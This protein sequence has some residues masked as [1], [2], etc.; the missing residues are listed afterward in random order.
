MTR[1]GEDVT[2]IDMWPENVEA[3]KARGIRVSGS[4]GPFSVQ[5]KIL[6]L[7]QTQSIKEQFDI[8]FIAVKSYDTLWATQFMEPYVKPEGFA[9]SSQNSINDLT[10]ASVFGHER[11]V[12]CV[13][14]KI[15]VGLFEPGHVTRGGSPGRGH[16]H[17]VF[18]VG[19]LSGVITPRVLRVVEL[20][21][22]VDGARATTNLW[23]E[24]WSKLAA[25]CQ[26][27][28]T[29][30]MSGLGSQGMAASEEARGLRM[31]ITR[32]VVQVGQALHYSLV[33]ILGVSP[34]VWLKIDD[35][36][37]YEELDAKMQEAG[38]V[39]WHA[40]MAQDV[41]KGRRTEV[42]YM[43]GL[44]SRRGKEVGVATPVNEAVVSVM[45]E[46]ES[47]KRKVGVE[48]ISRVLKK[49]GVKG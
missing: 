25:N 49:A 29:G 46:V 44:V 4:Q 2:L 30:A 33:P 34:E 8:V 13:M 47:G 32:E 39:D 43:N 20:V 11:T 37:V 45:R 28:P 19:E 12:G 6:H 1:E 3:I 15:E 38:K 16:G 41:M 36:S 10:V 17:D 7:H 9:V 22:S 5:P 23:G 40:S 35:G 48:N 26:S 24:R 42:E 18:R 14:S 27:N 31:L 21:S